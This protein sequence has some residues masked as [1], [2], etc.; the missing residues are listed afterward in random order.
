MQPGRSEIDEENPENLARA[1][2]K[3]IDDPKPKRSWWT[4]LWYTVLLGLG[5]FFTVLFIKGFI[6]ADDVDVSLFVMRTPFEC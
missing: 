1:P 5:I 3:D 2:S 4:I 6:E